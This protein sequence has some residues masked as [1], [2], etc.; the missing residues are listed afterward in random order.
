MSTF[1]NEVVIENNLMAEKLGLNPKSTN[2][3]FSTHAVRFT[4]GV[5]YYVITPDNIAE[6]NSDFK[7][8]LEYTWAKDASKRY[9]RVYTERGFTKMAAMS[10][11]NDNTWTIMEELISVYFGD[12]AVPVKGER[13]TFEQMQTKA[14]SISELEVREARKITQRVLANSE[15]TDADNE[16]LRV[17]NEQLRAEVLRLRVQD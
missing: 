5:D 9:F 7:S 2:K 17:D 16:R 11:V 1:N 4:Q 14:K 8:P 15:Y 10:R 13:F 6:F 3:S 12:K